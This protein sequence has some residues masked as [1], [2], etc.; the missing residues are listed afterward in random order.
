MS[1]RAGLI[2]IITFILAGIV[3]SCRYSIPPLISPQ[4]TPTVHQL[5]STLYQV[6]L[7]ITFTNTGMGNASRILLHVAVPHTLQPYQEVLSME[8]SPAKYADN[9]DGDGNHYLDILMTDLPA[10]QSREV[11]I[12]TRVRVNQVRFDLG[13]CQG[14]LPGQEIWAEKFIESDRRDIRSLASQLSQG[15]ATP[16]E[17][18][19]AFYNWE[20]DNFSYQGYNPKDVGAATALQDSGGDCT[21]FADVLAALSRASSIPARTVDGLTCCTDNGYQAG[22][23]KHSWVEVYFPGTGWV[24]IDPTWGRFPGERKAYF[25][26]LSDDHIW[27]TQGRNPSFLGGYHYYYYQY[28]WDGLPT[29]VASEEEWSV[30]KTGQ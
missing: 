15:K 12:K 29:Q 25:A 20:G 30:T 21:E 13:S 7:K 5:S 1:S 8:V 11:T 6:D 17:Q 18:V 19:W 22:D 24:S 23:N 3:L 16:C 28:W 26:A 2:S 27:I 14:S 10:G 9:Q 4:V